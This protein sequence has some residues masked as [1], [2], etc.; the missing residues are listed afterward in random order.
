MKFTKKIKNNIGNYFLKK[1][2]SKSNRKREMTNLNNAKKIGVLYN[3]SNEK[4]YKLIYHFV[5]GL[6]RNQKIVKALGFV[7]D[8]IIPHYCFPKLS[9]DFFTIKDLNWYHKPSNNFVN[10]FVKEEYDIIIDFCS[11]D[12]FPVQ[13]ITVL[14]KAKFKVGRYGK[15]HRDIYDMMIETDKEITLEQYIKQVTHYLTILNPKKNEQ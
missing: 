7:E 15:N 5:K 12:S 10:D 4:D 1:E 13:Y 9:F 3:A 8:S 11:E 14:S 2:L 6:Q